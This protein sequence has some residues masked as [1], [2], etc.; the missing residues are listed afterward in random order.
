MFLLAAGPIFRL[1][2]THQVV[3]MPF[4]KKQSLNLERKKGVANLGPNASAPLTTLIS[5]AVFVTIFLCYMNRTAVLFS[6]E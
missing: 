5:R 4:M 1:Q 6:V 2:S 3:E